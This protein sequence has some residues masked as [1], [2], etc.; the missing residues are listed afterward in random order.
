MTTAAV[1]ISAREAGPL[2]PVEEHALT[3]LVLDD[4]SAIVAFARV[5]AASLAGPSADDSRR[6]LL[7]AALAAERAAQILLASILAT[8]LAKGHARA[9]ASVN[10]ALDASVRRI[11]RLACAHR[12][13]TQSRRR[14]VM[15]VGHADIRIDG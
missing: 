9:V 3:T 13:E 10:A 11:E 1:S 15:L 7:A 2:H 14:P 12:A 8:Q 4:P 5:L 6:D